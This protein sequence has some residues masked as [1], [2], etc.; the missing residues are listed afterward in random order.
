MQIKSTSRMMFEIA[1]DENRIRKDDFA[2]GCERDV[3]GNG[4]GHHHLFEKML[5]VCLC[6][7][8]T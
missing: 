1:G 6:S 7:P 8:S 5:N 4:G 3:D 2:T